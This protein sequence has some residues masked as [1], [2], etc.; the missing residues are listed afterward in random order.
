MH[1]TTSYTTTL[2]TVFPPQGTDYENDL[3][4]WICFALQPSVQCQKLYAKVM[5][6]F[7]I[8]KW[9]FNYMDL[10]NILYKIYVRPHI[11]YCTQAWSLYY[12]KNI[13]LLEKIQHHG[14]YKI[15]T[16]ATCT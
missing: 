15:N 1:T 13:N 9:T 5:Q 14:G 10:H 4:I 3:E 6:S 7:A 8:I 16:P 2:I 12:A 11:E